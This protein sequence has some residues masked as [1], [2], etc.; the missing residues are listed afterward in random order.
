MARFTYTGST[1][2][3]LPRIPGWI[4]YLAA[5]ALMLAL[6]YG[7]VRYFG[8]YAEDKQAESLENAL[9]R[10]IVQCYAI[11]GVYPPNDRYLEEHYGLVYDKS[12]FYID[13]QSIGSNLYPDVTVL[14]L[15]RK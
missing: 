2:K 7:A 3:T 4:L 5:W 8:G 13:Y 15:R 11:E 9:R 12:R 10:S 14:D 6:F 1:G